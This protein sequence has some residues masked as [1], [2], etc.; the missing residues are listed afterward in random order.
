MPSIHVMSPTLASQV[1]A[2]E[3]VERPASVVKELVEN[4]LDAGAKSVRVEIRRGGV[5]L[6]KVADDGCGMSREDAQLCAKRHA[7]SKLSS[8]ED[9]FEITHL[10]F[11]GEAIPSIASVSRFKLCTRQQQALEGWEIRIDGGLE[12]EPRSS[13]VS[14]G[15]TIEVSDLF[16]NTPA[17]RKFLKSAETEA[18]HVEH[19]IRLHALAYPQVRFTYKRD[20]QLVFDLPATADL[21]VRISALTDAATAAALIP[22][23]TAIGPGI[24]VTGFLL[25]LSE[26]RRT[27]KG[28]Y[29]FMNTRPVEDQLINRAI[30][31]GYGG[32]PSGLHPALFLYMEV[33]PAL[34][35][36]NVHPAKKEVR[37]RRSADVVNTIVEA[38]AN[39][40]QKHARQEIHTAAAPEPDSGV[41]EPPPPA[42]REAPLSKIS[43]PFVPPPAEGRT[44]HA[45]SFNQPSLSSPAAR[46]PQG[47]APSP[48][49][50][51]FPLK[52][53]P[54]T[55][56]QWDF[57]HLERNAV[58]R[59]SS[60]KAVPEKDA[61]NGFSY[62]G[63]L[64]QQF[65]LFETPEGLVL[66]HPK[67]ARER[68]IFERLRAR[69]ES[70]M[71]SQQLLDPVM[72]DLDPRDFAVV[73]QFASH[74]DQA[75]MAVTPFGQN[76]IRIESIPA[77]LELE[78]VRA[79]LLELVDRL[80]QSE[81]SRNAK[82]MAY[83]TFIAEVARK[84]AWKERISPHRAPA[85]LKELLAC[86][87]PYCT[88]GG[89][90]TLVNY[91]IP[92][93]KRKF[94]IQA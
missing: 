37:F 77:L 70:P 83:E 91:S 6:I 36:V 72:L 1:A 85:I 68:I 87:V 53:V 49:L 15:T 28:Q 76:T 3:V 81:F 14:P 8:L 2:G 27:R 42:P 89:K 17:R 67:A 21:R 19:Q 16:Y 10:G 13:G 30:R 60:G 52:Q 39:T 74:F 71:P 84:S 65:A 63:T 86:E 51:P 29:V 80:T 25:P 88:P 33:E 69:R 61:A 66:M 18:S 90:P 38:I 35:D 46:Q 43:A 5:G 92:E 26:A 32:F 55:Q 56:G 7:T 34:V 4:S 20:D 58:A 22:I 59:N 44:A 48:T 73:Q 41:P 11:R 82:R 31:D 40:L 12:Q 24:S 79:F 54:S 64:R 23:E 93:I 57:Q 50:R 45:P 9:L 47:T 78:N 75:G 62:L 94:G